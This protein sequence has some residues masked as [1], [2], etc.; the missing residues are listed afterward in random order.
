[1]NV[2]DILG[3]PVRLEQW[4]L[5][6]SNPHTHSTVSQGSVD[7]GIPSLRPRSPKCPA[8]ERESVPSLML[9]DWIL[10]N[11][12][13][14][15]ASAACIA[16]AT[17]PRRINFSF[18]LHLSLHELS[19]FLC[20]P[21]QIY[22]FSLPMS[23]E[24]LWHGTKSWDRHANQKMA[25]YWDVCQRLM[26]II[27]SSIQFVSWTKY[28]IKWVLQHS[29]LAISPLL[30]PPQISSWESCNRLCMRGRSLCELFCSTH[31][32]FLK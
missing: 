5:H 32:C 7:P 3:M 27:V 24:W 12:S 21:H 1:M 11:A 30:S 31:F 17:N 13:S 20:N 14:L 29:L 15:S 16:V 19:L 8:L 28:W 25:S 10:P 26:H 18:A 4:T 9:S 23:C 6:Q 22:N 2:D